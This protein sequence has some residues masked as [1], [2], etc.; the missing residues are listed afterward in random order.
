MRA[1]DEHAARVA[2]A[3]G[4]ARLASEATEGLV[5]EGQFL[6]Q[7]LQRDAAARLEL[8]RLVDDTHAA[9]AEL[10]L[11]AEA[12]AFARQR[13]IQAGGHAPQSSG[14]LQAAP[15]LAPRLAARVPRLERGGGL[16][17]RSDII[18]MS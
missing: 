4:E 3:R 1:V 11:E 8:D 12:V 18:M 7:H 17:Y 2:D 6:G 10:A 9:T 5:V 15:A 16:R 13:W 14:A